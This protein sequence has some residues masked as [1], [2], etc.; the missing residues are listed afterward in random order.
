MSKPSSH[1]CSARAVTAALLVISLLLAQWL[2]LA[3]AIG[4]SGIAGTQTMS[5]PGWEPS[6]H[7][8]SIGHC[9]AF[10]AATLGASLHSIGLP[11]PPVIRTST[12]INLPVV[13]A[14]TARTPRHFD[15]R[16]PPQLA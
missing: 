1:S 15:S 3:H 6:Q 13:G 10:D 7:P 16:A 8:H 4:H 2:G 12:A 11:L 5:A 9:A 14:V